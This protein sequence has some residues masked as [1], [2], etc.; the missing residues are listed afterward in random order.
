MRH[1]QSNEGFPIPDSFFALVL[2]TLICGW[3]AISYALCIGVIA[4]TQEQANGFG[5]VSV[6]LFA[7]IGG[8]FVPS[9]AMPQSS[10][11]SSPHADRIVV[12]KLVLPIPFLHTPANR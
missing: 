9:F 6:V 7:A 1:A 2:V 11:S 12:A 5:A 4:N 3:C 8:I 10:G